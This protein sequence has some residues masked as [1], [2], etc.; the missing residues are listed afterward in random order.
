[1]WDIAEEVLDKKRYEQLKDLVEGD[2]FDRQLSMVSDLTDEDWYWMI[3]T[4]D[5]DDWIEFFGSFTDEDWND[6]FAGFDDKDWM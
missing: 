4:F 1:M 3:M 5:E 6:F 2:S